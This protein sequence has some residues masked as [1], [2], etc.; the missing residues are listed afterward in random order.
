MS[1]FGF[2]QKEFFAIH[3]SASKAESYFNS[4][5]RAACWY[6]RMTLEQIVEWLYRY[7]NNFSCY[8]TSLGARVHEPSFRNNVGENIFSKSTV[9][10]S[11]GNRAAHAKATKKADAV[12]AIQELFH[13]AYW[14][15]RTYGEKARPN[16]ALQFDETLVP[17]AKQ[18]G[19]V[20]IEQLKRQE[21]AL[22]AKEDEN[23]AL[24]AKLDGLNVVNQELEA[25]R[26]EFAAVKAANAKLLD[27]HDYNEEQTRDYFIDMLL[28]EAGWTL[29]KP[30]D[31]EYEVSGM[32]NSQNLGFVDYVLW[33]EDGLPL[34][35]VEAKRSR[36][37]PRIGQ[38]Q[39]KLY[40]DCLE[41]EFK[42][43][44]VIYYTNGYEHWLW[45]DRSAPPRR[46]QGFYKRTELELLM[47]RRTSKRSIATETIDSNIAGR[48]YQHQ[49]IRSVAEAMEQHN[50]RRSLIVMATGSGKTRTAIALVDLLSRCN[51]VK[52]VLF[53]A[54]RVSLVK[55]ATK[56]F[57]K[58]LP[59]AGVVN[60]LESPDGQGRVY[61]CTYPTMLNLINNDRNETKPFGVGH[62]DLVI[63]DEAHRSIYSKY[64]AIFNYFDSYL[65]G[66]TA[67]PKDEIDHNTYGMFQLQRGVP[68]YAYALDD[69][70]N[71]GYLVPPKAV[72]VELKFQ[73]QGIK[74]SELSEEEK[75][76]W[77]EMD[78]G[79]EGPPD[80]VDP[81]AL[82]GWLFNQDTI[83]K[84]LE[85]LMTKGERV[86]SGDRLGK[87]I[88]FAKN[89][90]HANFIA[91][92]FNVNYPEYN[93]EFARVITH[94]TKYAQSLIDSFSV[95]DKAPHIAISVD[96]LDTGIDVPEVVNLV[97]FKLVRSKT[98]F[99]QMI[100]RGTRLCPN[101]YGPDQD[102]KFFYIFDFLQNLEYFAENPEASDGATT[103]ALDTRIFKARLDLITGLDASA[104]RGG[105]NQ[106]QKDTI[107]LR[108]ET[109]D[110]LHK[111]VSGMTLANMI[112]R[113]KRKYVEKFGV[114]DI[115]KNLSE[116]D[117]DEA[118][119]ELANLP[120][121]LRDADEEAKRFDLLIIKTQLCI[122]NGSKGFD[123]LKLTIQKIALALEQQD[124]IPAIRAHMPL[125]Q[126]ISTDDWWQD[127]TVGI[128]ESTRKQLRL[129]IKL[130]EKSTKPIIYIELEDAISE[131]TDIGLPIKAS[132]LDYN[133]FKAK[134]RDFLNQHNDKLALQK[135]K[136][137]LPITETD[138]LEL[139]KLL[140]EQASGNA[141]FVDKARDESH[142]LGLFARS[143]V[144]L[145]RNAAVDALSE[146]LNDM[147]ATAS[148]IEF[149]KMIVDYLTVDGS[150]AD[151]RLYKAPFTSI[152]A[153]G[154]EAVFGPA[155]VERLFSVIDDI[156]RRAVA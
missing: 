21:E 120:T 99:W 100:G 55:Q 143:L 12:T 38:Q 94:E 139:E 57:N 41:A 96:M 90:L 61:V 106:L 35:V 14:L 150:I 102:K 104:S 151:E 141:S 79:E 97:F 18:E 78:W 60:L 129:L 27:T 44:P 16:P 138:L 29:D 73:R 3:D 50:Q 62:F 112:V 13:I 63:V 89:Q 39:A 126:S 109:A 92:R 42:R 93:G 113:P 105:G 83:D 22:K 5:A 72:S 142:G 32:P 7:D 51:W 137:N 71:D 136:R 82:N 20:S 114:A 1:N 87:T 98:K 76:R 49:A 15:A 23:S 88:M 43:R 80:Q 19:A 95:K 119:K 4:D 140:L 153:T 152:S 108:A 2:L 25:L 84:V 17:A 46:V 68:T 110:Q 123:R 47:Q 134:A 69:A 11:L 10:I 132:G 64:G 91:D 111:V 30:Q 149:A 103:D 74:Y 146:F 127:I 45:D 31:R 86:A 101:L 116:A 58:N 125:I 75:E 135:I 154:P 121:Q 117:A 128:L 77:D 28:H 115:W 52:R 26:A 70:I 6:A 155:K 67:T 40:A 118:G 145:D 147:N 122:L 24:K 124:S 48:G 130:T 37:D 156:R 107:S 9:V 131:G 133:K 56:E 148:Q 36:K 65:V 59:N 85:Y 144:G 34:A 53:L 66:L 54:D 33:G 81:A 8:E